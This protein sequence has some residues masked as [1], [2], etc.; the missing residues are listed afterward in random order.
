MAFT[1]KNPPEFTLDV[2]QWD[3][4]TDAD[5]V[6]MAKEIEKLL[7]NDAYLKENLE[8]L[9]GNVVVVGDKGVP[10]GVASLGS[11]GKVAQRVD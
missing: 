1:M 4:E 9:E 10:G 3:W 11:D 7:N 6:E 2:R 5:G 8:E